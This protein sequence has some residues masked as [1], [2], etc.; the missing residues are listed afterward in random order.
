[1]ANRAAPL[2]FLFLYPQEEAAVVLR[3][4]ED[5]G[6]RPRGVGGVGVVPRPRG[7]EEHQPAPALGRGRDKSVERK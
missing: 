2:F 7:G 5:M 4:R 3:T 6:L 1:M